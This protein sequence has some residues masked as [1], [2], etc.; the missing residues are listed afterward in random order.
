MISLNSNLLLM[1]L[2][3]SLAG[4]IWLAYCVFKMREH[5]QNNQAQFNLQSAD[6]QYI[7]AD[8]LSAKQEYTSLQTQFNALQNT[9]SD[10]L[11]TQ[12]NF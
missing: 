9:K 1:I 8:L 11:L 10:L 4:L 12:T 5:L 2:L 6:L 3:L 7:Q